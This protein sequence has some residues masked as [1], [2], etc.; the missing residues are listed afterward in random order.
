[1][2]F[3]IKEICTEHKNSNLKKNFSMYFVVELIRFGLMLHFVFSTLLQ[4]DYIIL[5]CQ[6][7][8]HR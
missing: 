8:A 7:R 2:H 5:S 4:G 3:C 6:Q 1:M